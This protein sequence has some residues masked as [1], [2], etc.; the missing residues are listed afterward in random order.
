MSSYQNLSQNNLQSMDYFRNMP[1]DVSLSWRPSEKFQFNI[2]VVNYPGYNYGNGMYG[3]A[4]MPW[5]GSP[6]YR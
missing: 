2:S 5:Y 6:M 1:F 3:S 4:F